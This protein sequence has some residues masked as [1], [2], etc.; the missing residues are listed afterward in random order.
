MNGA[1]DEI[2]MVEL[3]LS[4]GSD[5]SSMNTDTKTYYKATPEFKEDEDQVSISVFEE[6]PEHQE[7]NNEAEAA[8]LYTIKQMLN[9][10]SDGGL[11]HCWSTL[12]AKTF[13]V[14]SKSYLYDNQKVASD[15]SLFPSRGVD[16][17]MTEQFGP[18]NIGR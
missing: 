6:Q 15:K 13:Q 18:T 10:V 5:D 7:D 16:F 12:N 14:R 8:P 3:S 4:S 17:F 2:N 9:G 1:L 11:C